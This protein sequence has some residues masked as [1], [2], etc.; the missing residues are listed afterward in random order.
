MKGLVYHGEEV[1]KWEVVP[2][3]APADHEVKIRVKAAGICG[4]DIHG[5][6]GITGRRIPP[7]IMGH[8]FSGIVSEVGSGVDSLQV[9]DRVT[10]FPM[11]F[12]GTCPS[13]S[14]GEVQFCPG[15]KQFGVL[16]TNGAFADY[17][18]VP[19]KVCYK[20]QDTVSY[21]AGATVEPLAVAFRGV[22]HAGD[23]AG[24]NVLVVGSG[25]IGLMLV[26]CAKTRNPAKIFVSD[27]SNSR[28]EVAKLMGADVTINPAESEI[29]DLI[30]AHTDNR[31]IDVSFEAVGVTPACVQS[32]ENLRIGGTAVWLGQGK[33]TVEIGMLD[34]VTR[35][36]RVV[37]SFTYGLKEFEAAVEMLNSGEI[38]VAPII[39][40]EVPMSQ[41]AEWFEKLK[42]PEA[43]VKV[44]LTDEE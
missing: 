21:N 11:D 22:N 3:V 2:D 25:T 1:L 4:S 37:G 44:I 23:L 33:K 9:G 13:C 7:M 39:S 10:A 14:I 28:L 40:K 42:R 19:D 6:Q 34:I 32:L 38:N 16:T 5:Y 35:E 8:E 18:C 15:K 43:L 17:L 26:A 31:G 12:C 27:L 20:L 29:K 24:K 30:S 36:L 41:G